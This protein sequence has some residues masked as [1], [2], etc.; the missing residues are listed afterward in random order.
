MYRE[1]NT[2]GSVHLCGVHCLCFLLLN[3]LILD[4]DLW[5]D[6]RP[7]PRLGWNSRSTSKLKYFFLH[8]LYV[9]N[10]CL[11]QMTTPDEDRRDTEKIYNKMKVS[12]LDTRVTPVRSF[13][14]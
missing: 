11:F 3:H 9:L 2:L 5:Q 6:Y 12:E 14:V 1:N 8:H 7:R 10:V 4:L 13:T